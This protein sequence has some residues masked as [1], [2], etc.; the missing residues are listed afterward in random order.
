MS[1]LDVTKLM[2]SSFEEAH[3][4]GSGLYEAEEIIDY[5][6]MEACELKGLA[7]E[8]SSFDSLALLMAYSFLDD[9]YY[10]FGA[11]VTELVFGI[12]KVSIESV[13]CLP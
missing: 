13:Y 4:L 11:F 5:E 1:E 10:K 8:R 12:V 2:I 7:S 3:V 6:L 9:A